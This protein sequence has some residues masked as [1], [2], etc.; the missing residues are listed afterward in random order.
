MPKQRVESNEKCALCSKATG[1]S[2]LACK[3]CG[4]WYHAKCLQLSDEA[5]KVLQVVFPFPDLYFYSRENGN[6]S[7]HSQAP[8]NDEY[9]E[10]LMTKKY[11]NARVIINFYQL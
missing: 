11:I 5:Y 8:G 7:S 3:I 6:G 9:Y 10:G 2:W 1:D 4:D